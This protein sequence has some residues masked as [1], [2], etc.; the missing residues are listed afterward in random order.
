MTKKDI[1]DFTQEELEKIV[2]KLK[3]QP[4]RAEQV[5]FWLY[6][7]GVDNFSQMN[8]I[9]K[10]LQ[11]SLSENYLLSALTLAEHQ[12]SQDGVEK[13]LFRLSDANYIETVLIHSKYRQTICI[14][15][16]VGCKFRCLFC[17]S[18]SKGYVRNLKPAEIVNQVL[19]LQNNFLNT[20]TNYVFM[21]MGEPLDNYDNLSKALLIMN[22]EKAMNIG[23]RRMTI[24]TCGIIPGIDKLKKLGLQVNLS[25]SLHAADN[26]KRDKLMPVNKIYPLE[27]LITACEKFME[28]TGRIITLEYVLMKEKNDTAQDADALSVIAKRLNAK[29]NLIAYSRVGNLG[30]ES[31]LAKDIALFANRLR[32]NGAKVTVR[33]SRGKDIAAACGQLAGKKKDE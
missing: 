31:P 33:D 9:P 14:S 7:K 18:G 15:T 8:N 5:F 25:V 22:D 1:K 16:Q 17:A 20:I 28:K 32:K 30:L 10:S 19:F 2:L 4:Y 13:F 6:K 12:K 23:S 24:S 27:K 26:Q 11:R 29:V 3:E 21:G